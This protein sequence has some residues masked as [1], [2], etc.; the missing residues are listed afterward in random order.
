MGG[1]APYHSLRNKIEGHCRSNGKCG[2]AR[3][4]CWVIDEGL[5]GFPTVEVVFGGTVVT[6]WAP[7]SYLYRKGRSN[8][9]CYAF[10]N[11]GANANTV[12]GASWMIHKEIIFDMSSNQIGIVNAK[13]PEYK[14][15]PPHP[16]ASKERPAL[17]I[18]PPLSATPQHVAPPAVTPQHFGSPAVVKVP[19]VPA[20][21]AQLSGPSN[22]TVGGKGETVQAYAQAY[23][24]FAVVGVLLTC[25]IGG[26]ARSL[27][28]KGQHSHARIEQDV[29][30]S[31][32][33]PQIVGSVHEHEALANS[34]DI[35][36]GENEDQEGPSGGEEEAL[37]AKAAGPTFHG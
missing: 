7:K 16:G 10:Q 27:C 12:L 25:A 6:Q 31:G 22:R 11:D 26:I 33:P 8:S 1:S 4:S 21:T 34:E 14:D 13:C 35:I 30:E 28:R 37:A 20:A 18:P 9:W 19:V 32:L 5:A 23:A 17:R 2:L 3:G 24:P 36:G 15:R 29:E